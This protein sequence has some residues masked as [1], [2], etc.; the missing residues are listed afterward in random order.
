MPEKKDYFE[1]E[2]NEWD[3]YT[4]EGAEC[5]VENDEISSG[6]RGFMLGY[7]CAV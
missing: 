7:M 6:E 1:E 3:I 4:E 2:D 5:Y